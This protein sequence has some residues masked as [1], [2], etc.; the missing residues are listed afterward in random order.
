MRC[1]LQTERLAIVW[2][3]VFV[4]TCFYLQPSASYKVDKATLDPLSF[5]RHTGIR[6][7]T[8]LLVREKSGRYT[9]LR[10]PL[11][12]D[13]CIVC[14]EADWEDYFEVQEI[15]SKETFIFK[16]RVYAL[17]LLISQIPTH[18]FKYAFLNLSGRGRC[19][20]QTMVHPAAVPFA[21]NG[22]LAKE[23]QRTC[24]HYDQRDDDAL[25][26][27]LRYLRYEH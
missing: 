15:S 9:L 27:C 26:I 21:G 7:A 25:L 8:L 22:R 18:K 6:E 3:F 20:N 11:F 17:S 1:W 10:E 5:P 12:L 2:H 23:T 13:R 4:F 14:T 24:Q 16:V 19:P